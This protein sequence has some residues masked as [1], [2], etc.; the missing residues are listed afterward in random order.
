[1]KSKLNVWTG[2][3]SCLGLLV[4]AGEALSQTE[5]DAALEEVIVRSHPLSAEG[6]SQPVTVLAGNDLNKALAAVN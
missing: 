6:L 5:S 2:L 1:M 3:A 4:V